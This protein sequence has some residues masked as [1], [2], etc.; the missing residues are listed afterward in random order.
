[1]AINKGDMSVFT[2]I[3]KAVLTEEIKEFMVYYNMPAFPK[4]LFDYKINR[5]ITDDD[6]FVTMHFADKHSMMYD[7]FAES[8]IRNV[9]FKTVLDPS[10]AHCAG[11]LMTVNFDQHHTKVA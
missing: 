5:C 9:V 10:N 6:N 2:N 1:V 7:K 11:P 8:S 3:K 4:E